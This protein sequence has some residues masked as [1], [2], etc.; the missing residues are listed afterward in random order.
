M[1]RKT[2]ASRAEKT[3]MTKLTGRKEERERQKEDPKSGTEERKESRRACVMDSD[4]QTETI[5]LRFSRSVSPFFLFFFFD[6][7]VFLSRAPSV[8]FPPSEKN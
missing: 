7:F 6:V 4:R 5:L 2:E 1:V 3:K 8:S